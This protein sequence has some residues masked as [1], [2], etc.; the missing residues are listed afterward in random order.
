VPIQDPPADI[1]DITR[2]CLPQIGLKLEA[3]K[4]PVEKFVIDHA[5]KPLPN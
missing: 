4:G 2:T 1:L 5:E 3:A